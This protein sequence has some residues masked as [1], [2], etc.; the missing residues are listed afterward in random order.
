[1]VVDYDRCI[2]CRYCI[3]GL[4]VRGALLRLR[5]ELRA[6]RRRHGV[7]AG[8]LAGVRAVPRRAT[9]A[10][11][12]IG[13]VRKCTFCLHLQ[14]AEGRVRQGGRALAGVRQD[15]HGPRDL[16][17]GL[18][19]PRER[20]LA[21]AARAAG[22]PAQ[23]RARHRAQ[24]LLPAVRRWRHEPDTDS[25]AL[26]GRRR[27]CS[28]AS[29]RGLVR[30]PGVNGHLNANYGSVVP[31]GLWVAAYI[32]F[33]GL[34]R[35]LVPDLLARLRLQDQAVRADRAAGGLHRGRH[36]APGAALDLGRPRAHGPGLARAR[37]PELQVAD[38]L[39]DLALH[40]LL[41]RCSSSSSGSCCG[42]DL[43][44]GLEAPGLARR[45]STGC[46]RSARGTSPRRRAARDR[47]G[48]AD[49]GDDRRAGGH[50]V[51]RRRRRAVRRGGRPARLAQ[52]DVPDPL[53]ALGAGQRRRAARRDRARSSRTA[54]G[55]NRDTVLA[56]GQ[57]VPGSAA[58]R[59]PVPDLRDAGRPL[60]RHARTHRRI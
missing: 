4:P 7:R 12:P 5:R 24:R 43:V 17:R 42:A 59:R 11:R 20:G 31:W 38:G 46:C 58:P 48:R 39:D 29:A 27:R 36:A 10:S 47:A 23:G 49:P 53:P 15:L 18:Q 51:P 32:Y 3:T 35:R 1:M 8:A 2:G 30:P 26:L 45:R 6:G 40:R 19:R 28:S 16:L 22:D 52:R 41:P 14:D 50:H 44:A 37:L 33:I 57:I 34:S 13:N 60:R 25:S 55:S 56:L 21:A 9:A 54:G